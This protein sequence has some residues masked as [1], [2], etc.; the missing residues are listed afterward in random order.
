MKYEDT[1]PS[2]GS[3]DNPALVMTLPMWSWSSA[4]SRSAC[5]DPRA[6]ALSP[7]ATI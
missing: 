5:T 6:L 4:A 3:P 7:D 1:E 2:S